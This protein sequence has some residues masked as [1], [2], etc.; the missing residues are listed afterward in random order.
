MLREISAEH[1]IELMSVKDSTEDISNAAFSLIQSI[2]DSFFEITYKDDVRMR[3]NDVQAGNVVKN[4]LF[5]IF[6]V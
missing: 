5:I 3:S 2:V 1:M 6:C 4:F